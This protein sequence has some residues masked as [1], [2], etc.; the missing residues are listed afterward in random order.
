M[1]DEFV[2]KQP[3]TLE[4]NSSEEPNP[5]YDLGESYVAETQRSGKHI[6]LICTNAEEHKHLTNRF[7]EKLN[8]KIFDTST[9]LFSNMKVDSIQ[10]THLK[11]SVYNNRAI[12]G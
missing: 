1:Q 2:A 6:P 12:C 11:I 7:N 3:A 9:D 5:N 4:E 10:E 8:K